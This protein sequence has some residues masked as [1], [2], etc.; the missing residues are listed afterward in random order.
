MTVAEY[1][2]ANDATPVRTTQYSYYDTLDIAGQGSQSYIETPQWSGRFL[3]LVKR[4]SV[5]EGV[6][7][8]GTLRARTEY[9]YDKSGMSTYN[10]SGLP[11][12]T[13]RSIG[14]TWN[15]DTVRNGIPS[16]TIRGNLTKSTSWVTTTGSEIVERSGEYDVYGNAVRV[17]V[18]CCREKRYTYTGGTTGLYYSVP[19]ELEDGS[20]TDQLTTTYSYDFNTSLLKS[21]EAP[22][23]QDTFYSYD[24]ARRVRVVTAPT[25][26]TTLGPERIGTND[27]LI[28]FRSVSYQEG[29]ATTKVVTSKE[30]VNGAGRPMRVAREQEH[31][32]PSTTRWPCC[33]TPKGGP[34]YNRTHTREMGADLDHQP[35][36]LKVFTMSC[37][38]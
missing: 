6:T 10:G 9:E 5:Y 32:R 24:S 35:T 37:R 15:Y 18:S 12:A 1:K 19:V 31:P 7:G 30:W 17:D 3:H 14:T 29:D 13:T 20:G 4:V 22:D 16:V 27:Q 26:T 36:G 33:T 23:G 11:P 34:C 21:V 25:L 2:N 38:E 8:S 28:Y